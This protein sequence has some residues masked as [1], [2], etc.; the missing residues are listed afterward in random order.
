MSTAK[1]VGAIANLSMTTQRFVFKQV[2][3]MSQVSYNVQYDICIVMNTLGTF[4]ARSSATSAKV[5]SACLYAL[6]PSFFETLTF[7]QRL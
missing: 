1:T 3:R 7:L 4:R 6:Y 5:L 2:F